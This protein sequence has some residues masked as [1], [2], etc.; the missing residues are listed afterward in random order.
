VAGVVGS[1]AWKDGFG[2]ALDEGSAVVCGGDFDLLGVVQHAMA[3][4][5]LVGRGPGRRGRPPWRPCA[6]RHVQVAASLV[7]G[8]W[9]VAS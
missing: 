7:E 2:A 1:R 3:V 9:R 4:A 6:V 5:S 8:A